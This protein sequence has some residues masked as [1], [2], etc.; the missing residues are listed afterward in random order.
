[1][2]IF[3]ATVFLGLD[4]GYVYGGP[5]ILFETMIFFPGH[6]DLDQWQDRYATED[7]ARAGHEVAVALVQ[8]AL[9]I[10]VPAIRGGE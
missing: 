5:P 7:E 3:A 4:Y 10:G 2:T 6:P 9:G 1:M 8:A